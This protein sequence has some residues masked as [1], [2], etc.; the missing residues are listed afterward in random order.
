MAFVQ[1]IEFRTSQVEGVRK[2]TEEFLAA[3]EGKSTAQRGLLCQDRDQPDRYFDLVF[4][5]SYEAAMENSNLPETQQ[6]AEKMMSLTDGQPT[7]YNLDVVEDR[8]DL[9]GG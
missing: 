1:I 5:E 6:F 3:T 4:F 7:F 9:S 2:N 8:T